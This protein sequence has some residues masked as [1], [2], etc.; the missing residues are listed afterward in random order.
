M[1]R[2]GSGNGLC[3]EWYPG[4]YSLRAP[5]LLP[6]RTAVRL[7]TLLAIPGSENIK[8]ASQAGVGSFNRSPVANGGR[9]NTNKS[10]RASGGK[11]KRLNAFITSIQTKTIGLHKGQAAAEGIGAKRTCCSVA[12][13]QD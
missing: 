6:Y 12:N 13:G 4:Y 9:L 7:K 11:R 3:G 5:R 10:G 8:H 1:I 2:G